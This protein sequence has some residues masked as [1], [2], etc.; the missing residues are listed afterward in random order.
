MAGYS[1]NFRFKKIPTRCT[2]KGV[3]NAFLD[4]SGEDDCIFFL[5]YAELILHRRKK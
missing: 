2:L 4:C 1:C 5:I 3:G